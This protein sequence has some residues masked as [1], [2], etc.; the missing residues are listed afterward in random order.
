MYTVYLLESIGTGKWYI[1][2]TPSDV[3]KRLKRHNDG[4]VASTKP[5]RPWE[6]IYYECYVN[7][8]DA[9]GREKFLKSGAGRSFLKK[10]LRNYLSINGL[11]R[12]NEVSYTRAVSSM[13]EQ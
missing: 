9:T 4:E 10:Q 5:F 11:P 12:T 6:I 7:R 8:N 2:Y 3:Q 1:G 13:V